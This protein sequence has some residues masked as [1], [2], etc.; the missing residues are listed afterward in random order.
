[1][2]RPGDA[3]MNISQLT[4]TK[5]NININKAYGLDKLKKLNVTTIHIIKRNTPLG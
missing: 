2:T 4:T 3:A 1:M 5:K